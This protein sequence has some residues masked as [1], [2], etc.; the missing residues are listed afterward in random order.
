MVEQP[1]VVVGTPGRVRE[2]LE[3]EWIDIKE[4]Q[5][6]IIDEADKFCQTNKNQKQGSKFYEDLKFLIGEV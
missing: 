3:R 1:Q 6:M 4:V 2:M 5:T